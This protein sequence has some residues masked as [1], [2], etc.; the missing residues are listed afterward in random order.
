LTF[1]AGNTEKD[2][3]TITLSFLGNKVNNLTSFIK[4]FSA[5][6]FLEQFF[7]WIVSIFLNL[8]S[9]VDEEFI[10][11]NSD[12]KSESHLY[13]ENVSLSHTKSV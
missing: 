5:I 10:L 7:Q 13:N 6:K 4:G 12:K 3:S 9:K 11:K 8:L 1:L 2:Q